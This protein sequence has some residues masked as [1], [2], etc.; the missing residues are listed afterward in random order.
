KIAAAVGKMRQQAIESGFAPAIVV[1]LAIIGAGAAIE[2]L[3][4]RTAYKARFGSEI[5]S[6]AY[7]EL[8][9]PLV[10]AVVSAL[11]FLA[12]EWPPLLRAVVLYGLLAVIGYRLATGLCRLSMDVGDTTGFH[13]VRI[14]VFGA[15]LALGIAVWA[16]C[17]PLGIDADT[18]AVITYGFS[19]ALVLVVLEAIWRRPHD[20]FG[21]LP[22][23]TGNILSSL[24]LGVL[25]LLWMLGFPG[26]F[27]LGIYAIA[28]PKVTSAADRMTKAFAQTHWNEE[29]TNTLRMVLLV[30]GVRA[31]VILMALGWLALVWEYNPNAIA[32]QSPL[33]QAIGNGLLKSVIVLLLADL[34]WQLA[35]AYIDGTLMPAN[36]GDA[37][38][39]DE[40]ARRAR[41]RTLLP[42][43]RN[44]LAAVLICIA[45]MTILAEMGVQIGPLIAGAGIFGVAIGF[46]SQTLVKDIVSGIFYLMDDA[47]RVGEW[48]ESGSY[49]G[50]VESFSLRSI[51]LRH[52]RGSVFTVPFGELGAIRN[53]SRDWTVDKFRVR[54]PFKTDM[55][56]VNK[57]AKEIGKHLLEDPELAPHIIKT[58]KLKGV[59]QI[60]EFGIEISFGFTAR[61]TGEQTAI[62]RR[63]YT[64]LTQAFAENDIAF[65]QPTFQVGGDEKEG[66]AAA[67][68]HKRQAD[69]A[70]QAAA[71]GG[72]E[73]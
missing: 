45:V 70:A 20:R 2:W 39:A 50:V 73:S 71:G 11:I 67:A 57:I 15:I 54:V 30:R 24:Y 64:M 37:L 28:L 72:A 47:F 26:L 5:V 48:I 46:G 12:F 58:L 14:R 4:R 52:H 3:F 34:V 19:I 55:T 9:P 29:R 62:R 61:P 31:I 23:R 60:G 10:F 38:T 27:W 44:A 41:L 1:F 40:A 21:N 7:A 25:W 13:F 65:A 63:A 16:M 49:N 22:S 69:L 56:K 18:R 68:M 36:G 59:E 33:L 51:R 8:G 35:K 6:R 42:I 17:R 43:F 66:A 32:Q 53:G